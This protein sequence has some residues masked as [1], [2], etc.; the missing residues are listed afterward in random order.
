MV[1]LCVGYIFI[2]NVLISTMLILIVALLPYLIVP[3][4]SLYIF[5]RQDIQP[6]W[7]SYLLTFVVLMIYPVL[8]EWLSSFSKA[9]D[10][11]HGKCAPPMVL[12]NILLIPI[13]LALQSFL[14]FL[15]SSKWLQK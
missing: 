5:K 2:K 8:L 7:L 11:L 12:I 3:W 15:Y 6:L 9:H 10:E 1:V 14:S 13:S 4:Y